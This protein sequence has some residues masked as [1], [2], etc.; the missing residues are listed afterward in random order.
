MISFLSWTMVTRSDPSTL[1]KCW[2]RCI[3][4]ER[5]HKTYNWIR[6][7][8]FFAHDPWNTCVQRK[9]HVSC[10]RRV[11]PGWFTLIP[12]QG[13]KLVLN[14]Q[15]QWNPKVGCIQKHGIN[16]ELECMSGKHTWERMIGPPC[17]SKSPS[18]F[19]MSTIFV[20]NFC[21]SACSRLTLG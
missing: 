5:K 3:V 14:L 19:I 11:G 15:G 13:P 18:D 7:I 6:R 8:I 21:I 17:H 9:C 12:L 20:V 16:T 4:K 1:K 10:P 2:P